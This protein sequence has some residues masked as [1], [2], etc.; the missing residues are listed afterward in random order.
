MSLKGLWY[1]TRQSGCG[2]KGHPVNRVPT[3]VYGAADMTSNLW[4]SR[5]L[6]KEREMDPMVS[7]QKIEGELVAV[8]IFSKGM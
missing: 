3:Q 8:D 5:H 4:N 6:A 7:K 1:A 2:F